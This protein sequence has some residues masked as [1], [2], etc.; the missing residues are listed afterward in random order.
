[1]RQWILVICIIF[2]VNAVQSQK[3][4][5]EQKL[6]CTLPQR[7]PLKVLVTNDGRP[8]KDIINKSDL[9]RSGLNII[10][11]DTSYKIIGF[12]VVYGCHPQSVFDMN[13]KTYFT[14]R[15]EPTDWFINGVWIGDALLFD[16]INVEKGGKRF[17]VEA[18][19]FEVK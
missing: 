13:E 4:R 19:V 11:R 6:F 5:Q 7:L 8:Q 12:K 10:L 17:L 16:C 1:M 18:L 2:F 15:I 14:Q 9:T 3:N